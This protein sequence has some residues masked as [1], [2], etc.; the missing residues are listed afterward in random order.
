MQVSFTSCR[1]LL[2]DISE[3]LSF[4]F[5]QLKL[6]F[7]LIW[8]CTVIIK[9]SFSLACEIELDLRYIYSEYCKNNLPVTLTA[10]HFSQHTSVVSAVTH[11]KNYC[12]LSLRAVVAYCHSSCLEFCIIVL[13]LC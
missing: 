8:S 6:L 9:A 3:I 13:L 2:H 4:L 11:F 7:G 5:T 1:A 12:L 10:L